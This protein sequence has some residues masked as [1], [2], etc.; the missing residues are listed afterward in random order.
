MTTN[1]KLADA[2]L[3]QVVRYSERNEALAITTLMTELKYKGWRNLGRTA[4]FG[5][6]LRQLGFTVVNVWNKPSKTSK[7][8]MWITR[9]NVTL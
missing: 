5:S 7:G 8:G 1:E 3:E 6:L 2:I 9:Q 4:E